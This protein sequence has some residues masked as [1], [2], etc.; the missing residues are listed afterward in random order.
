LGANVVG[1]YEQV[2]NYNFQTAEQYDL[3][4]VNLALD[5]LTLC[6]N[7]SMYTEIGSFT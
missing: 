3:K 5:T 6:A 4:D 2:L 1:Y 7:S